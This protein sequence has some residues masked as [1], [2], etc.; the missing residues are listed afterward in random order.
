[1]PQLERSH[2]ATAIRRIGWAYFLLHLNINLGSLNILP[3]WW[4]YLLIVFS[5]AVLSQWS[6][7]AKLLRPLGCF[8][9]AAD[10]I[11]WMCKTLN[12]SLSGGPFQSA[13]VMLNLLVTLI[14]LYF[15]FQLLTDIANAAQMTDYGSA[16]ELLRTRTWYTVLNTILYLMLYASVMLHWLTGVLLVI[17]LVIAIVICRQILGFGKWL[18]TPCPPDAGPET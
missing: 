3:N 17:N 7:S 8:L 14:N 18:N 5:L 16:Q 2:L 9:A 15:H 4:G 1:M 13:S 11:Q 6:P 10:G 12:L